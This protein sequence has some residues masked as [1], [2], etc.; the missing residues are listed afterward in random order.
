MTK[1]EGGKHAQVE[2][3]G[4]VCMSTGGDGDG[5]RAIRMFHGI[6]IVL[7]GS[8]I[9]IE[10]QVGGAV[11]ERMIED[12]FATCKNLLFRML[13]G[14][15][16]KYNEQMLP[17]LDRVACSFS[18]VD[19]LVSYVNKCNVKDFT[20]LVHVSDLDLKPMTLYERDRIL[21]RVRL[22]RFMREKWGN[23]MSHANLV[24][25][26]LKYEKFIYNSAKTCF[27]YFDFQSGYQRFLSQ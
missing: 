24:E 8:E 25:E 23:V 17:F 26:V 6:V 18:D 3:V 27:E 20:M 19:D 21:Y 22:F 11:Y 9:V 7:Q 10:S 5:Y 15:H 16:E 14:D 12:L 2:E 4:E 13:E 1:G